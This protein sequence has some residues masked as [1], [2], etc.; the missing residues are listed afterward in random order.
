MREQEV[1]EWRKQAEEEF[2][3][4]ELTEDIEAFISSNEFLT[5]CK[6]AYTEIKGELGRLVKN[7]TNGELAESISQ[8]VLRTEELFVEEVIFQFKIRLWG[9][10]MTLEEQLYS[11]Q[12]TRDLV[13]LDLQ[14]D[15]H[16]F[17]GNLEELK[18]K[19]KDDVTAEY[20]EELASAKNP[21]R[22]ATILMCDDGPIP[23]GV[24]EFLGMLGV[25]RASVAPVEA[26]FPEFS[27][28]EK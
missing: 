3:R 28:K 27:K 11:K 18:L 20:Q 16:F 9:I 22:D 12:L 6:K 8:K 2:E 5:F 24:L 25:E 14:S 17:Q 23:E 1:K 4:M 19:L 10:L 13:L 26:I 15:R 21:F 7:E